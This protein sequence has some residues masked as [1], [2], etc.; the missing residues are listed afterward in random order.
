MSYARS[1]RPVCSI[2]MGTSII[3]G[4]YCEL[5]FASLLTD[6]IPPGMLSWLGGSRHSPEGLSRLTVQKLESFFVADSMTDSIQRSILRQTR[7]DRF[8]RL[9]GLLRNGFDLAIHLFVV[10][11]EL[12]EFG[13]ALEQQGRLHFLLRAFALAGTEAVEIHALHVFRLHSL[14]G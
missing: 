2:T 3:C 11:F 7:S 1:P 6:R 9:F 5:P 14:R 10:D 12:F 8:G 4:L 13:D